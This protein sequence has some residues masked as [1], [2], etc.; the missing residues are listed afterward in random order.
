LTIWSP[1]TCDCK[2]EYN[3]N[4]NWVK[5][6]KKCRLHKRFDGQLLLDNV[7]EQNRRFNLAFGSID[8]TEDQQKLIRTARDVN[9]LRIRVEN[10]D[11]FDE[12]LPFEQPLTFF[13]NLRRV[14]RL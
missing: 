1:D 11:N 2:I 6:F 14:L 4:T 13:Q 8:L 3:R 5:T 10:L 7:L 9:K 12:H